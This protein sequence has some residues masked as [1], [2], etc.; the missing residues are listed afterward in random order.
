M[1]ELAVANAQLARCLPVV[2]KK[3]GC[4]YDCMLGQS[5]DKERTWRI[6]WHGTVIIGVMEYFCVNGKCTHVFAVDLPCDVI[7]PP[8]AANPNCRLETPVIECKSS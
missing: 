1:E 6:D 7:C 2:A 3:C 4:T 8:T 5:W